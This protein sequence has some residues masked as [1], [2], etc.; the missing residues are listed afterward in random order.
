MCVLKDPANAKI[1]ADAL[2]HFDSQRY[3]LASFVVMPNHVHVLFRPL[4]RHALPEIMKS[5]KG[6]TARDINRRIGKAGSL[7]QDE[8]WDRLIRNEAH[9]LK[10][11]KYIR[12]NPVKAKL[13]DG[14]FLLES[15]LSSPL[16]KT[17]GGQECPPSVV[18]KA[19]RI[20]RR[21][22]PR[23]A[24]PS[25]RIRSGISFDYRPTGTMGSCTNGCIFP[26]HATGRPGRSLM[27]AQLG[28]YAAVERRLRAP[29]LPTA[30][31]TDS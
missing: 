19:F 3:E 26:F 12:E 7:W 27:G 16:P 25:R 9:F 4:G 11:V 28:D 31:A 15:G 14:Q 6:F 1:V 21:W 5:W 17:I 23:C 20:P 13:R 24:E 2:W 18:L 8:Y 10:V 30:A 22:P 29:P